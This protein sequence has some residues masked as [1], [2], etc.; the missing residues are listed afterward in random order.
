MG[1]EPA[2]A[3]SL[4]ADFL[5][6]FWSARNA[7]NL[8]LGWSTFFCIQPF[9][10]PPPA[11]LCC[12]L[13]RQRQRGD[14]EGPDRA[15]VCCQRTPGARATPPPPPWF[16][17][18]RPCTCMLQCI[19]ACP[20][21][22]GNSISLYKDRCVSCSCSDDTRGLARVHAVNSLLASGAAGS[23]RTRSTAPRYVEAPEAKPAS[24]RR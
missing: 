15:L 8:N 17:H 12:Q 14:R 18:R 20:C 4:H 1:F 22:D 23:S 16:T 19:I 6:K 3:R 10:W 21:I 24:S 9:L 11:A 13:T 5:A 7:Q 2:R